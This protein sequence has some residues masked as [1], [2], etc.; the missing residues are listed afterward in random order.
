MSPIDDKTFHFYRYS[1]YQRKANKNV[2]DRQ[3]LSL[4]VTHTSHQQTND[5]FVT[6]YRQLYYRY[7]RCALPKNQ[8]TKYG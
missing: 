3:P 2:D 8:P 1:H 7:M 4:N 5:I 6:D